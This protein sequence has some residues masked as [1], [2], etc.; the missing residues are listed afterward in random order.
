MTKIN[1]RKKYTVNMG[2][3]DGGR[4]IAEILAHASEVEEMAAEATREWLSGGSWPAEGCEV[5][6]SYRVMRGKVEVA[7][8]DVT[9][10]IEPDEDELMR[11]A[12][13]DPDCDHEWIPSGGCAENPGVYGSGHGRCGKIETCSRCGATRDEDW[14]ATDDHGEVCTRIEFKK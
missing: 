9:V 2:C 12:G 4:E 14:G 6:G 13:L 1:G 8:G 5:S 7:T 3:E 10:Q 11:E